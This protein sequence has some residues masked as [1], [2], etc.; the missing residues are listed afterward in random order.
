[1][2]AMKIVM[3]SWQVVTPQAAAAA[4]SERKKLDDDSVVDH[5]KDVPPYIFLA[6][7]PV[8]DP[9]S[10]SY[11][12]MASFRINSDDPAINKNPSEIPFSRGDE[13]EFLEPAVVSLDDED[14]FC[15]AKLSGVTEG[16]LYPF[17]ER[18]MVF[19]KD[20]SYPLSVYDFVHKWSQYSLCLG[21]D[22]KSKQGKTVMKKMQ[23]KY[24]KNVGPP[25]TTTFQSL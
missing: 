21:Y 3:F 5:E 14:I 18:L 7:L 4:V 12:K 23:Q 13:E 10:L 1:M 15:T 2:K 25:P 19:L 16:D 20:N 8:E 9:D 24:K 17:Q 22:F 11:D 6:W